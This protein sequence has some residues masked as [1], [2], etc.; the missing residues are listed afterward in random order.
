MNIHESIRDADDWS[1]FD[2]PAAPHRQFGTLTAQQLGE[3]TFAPVRFVVPGIL[4]EGLTILA[5]KPKFGKSFLLM[6]AAIAVATGGRAFGNIDCEAGSVLYLALED[7]ERRLQ[8]RLFKLMPLAKQLRGLPEKL[9]L[10][11]TA[12][13]LDDGL[14]DRLENW[15]TNHPDARLIILDTWVHI[16]PATKGNAS[17]YDEDAKGLKPLHHFAKRHPGLAVVVV[18]HTRKMDADDVFDTI[19]GTNGLSGVVDTQIVLARHGDVVKLSGQGRDIEGYEKALQREQLTGGW[20]ITGDAAERAK[21]SERQKLL[22]VLKEADGEPLRT[23][24]IAK[25]AG[26]ISDSSAG[27]RLK[28]LVDEGLVVKAGYGKWALASSLSKS[29]KS[30]KSLRDRNFEATDDPSKSSN[31]DDSGGS[32]FDD[33]DAASKFE[34]AGSPLNFDDFDD[35][36]GTTATPPTQTATTENTTTTKPKRRASKPRASKTKGN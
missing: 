32:N 7:G 26:Q 25:A 33:F 8:D 21:T 27:H 6:G 34:S 18:H 14:I 17:A 4:P 3:M 2:V 15:V 30:S 35:F 23:S 9:W 24:T 10:E 13:S 1:R 36:D 20:I 31:L 19:S 22:E 5:G 29:S 11:T 28:G 12:P 16:K